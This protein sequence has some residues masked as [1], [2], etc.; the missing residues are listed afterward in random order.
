VNED[1]R[2]IHMLIVKQLTKQL[3]L[4]DQGNKEEDEVD[5]DDE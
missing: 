5:K 1:M 4:D 2:R 3:K